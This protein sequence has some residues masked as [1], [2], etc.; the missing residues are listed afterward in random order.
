MKNAATGIL[1]LAPQIVKG[2]QA[3]SALSVGLIGCGRRGTAMSAWF[4]KNEFARMAALCDIYD[5]QI[6]QAA[7]KFAGARHFKDINELLASD[8]DAVYIATP[9][10][11]HPPHF[12]LAVKARKHIF[13]EKPAGVDPA[14]VK[15]IVAAAKTA[16][17]NKRITVDFQQ[18]YGKDYK[19]AYEI[20]QSGRL[21]KIVEVRAS[22]ISGGLPLRDG[23]PADQEEMRNWLFYREKSGDIIVEQ[24][25][26]NIDVVNWFTGLHPARAFGYGGRMVRKSPGNILDNLAATYRFDNGLVFSYSSSQISTNGYLDVSETFVCEGGAINTSRKGYHVWQGGKEVETAVTSYDIT[27][28]AIDEFVD[29]ARNGKFDNAAFAAAE[30][31]LTAIMARESI[32]SG[33]Q[34]TWEMMQ[35]S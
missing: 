20:V 16:D 23:H 12:E 1:I 21:G 29:G 10:Y 17:K 15:R 7:Q 2:Y 19:K 30:S 28:D 5:D 22:W 8:V 26:H 6:E 14:G 9:P 27:K 3:N 24:N 25:C 31:T 32:Y 34:K 35:A 11:L 33:N 13:M 18:R 4:A